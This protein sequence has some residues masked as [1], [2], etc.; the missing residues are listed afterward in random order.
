[1]AE[2]ALLLVGFRS[3]RVY[4]KRDVR[5]HYNPRTANAK[6][7]GTLTFT[8]NSATTRMV[9]GAIADSFVAH[10]EPPA[11]TATTHADKNRTA[12]HRPRGCAIPSHVA[13]NSTPIATMSL[14]AGRQ[15]AYHKY[16]VYTANNARI[17]FGTNNVM[18]TASICLS[19][20][21]YV[22]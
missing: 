5:V 1:M 16:I 22:C 18:T 11:C 17:R 9:A 4:K 2:H 19:L 15:P 20:H 6:N 8:T 14:A 13:P 10:V 21:E 7:T 3:D 12:I